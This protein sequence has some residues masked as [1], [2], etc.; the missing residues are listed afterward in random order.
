MPP[1]EQKGGGGLGKCI[2]P[3]KCTVVLNHK[4]MI[5]DVSTLLL[6]TDSA[7]LGE[8]DTRV[9]EGSMIFVWTADPAG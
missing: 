8:R 3:A 7:L 9:S 6:T 4:K 2:E 1:A 5:I